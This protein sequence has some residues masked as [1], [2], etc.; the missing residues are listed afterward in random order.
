M[1]QPPREGLW[2]AIRLALA[3]VGLGALGLLGAFMGLRPRRP[4][5]AYWL[6]VAGT[7]AFFVQTA[8]LDLFVWTAF[9][10]SEE[11]W[12][13]RESG[14]GLEDRNPRQRRQAA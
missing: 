12:A 8:G 6:A 1:I 3:L 10:R 2:L 14:R 9:F 13:T 11:A 5:S 7:A 4:S